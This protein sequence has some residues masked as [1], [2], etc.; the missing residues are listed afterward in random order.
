MKKNPCENRLIVCVS[1]ETRY[2]KAASEETTIVVNVDACDQCKT[3]N[4]PRF[5]DEQ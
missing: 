3:M 5:L 4:E 2:R 1:K